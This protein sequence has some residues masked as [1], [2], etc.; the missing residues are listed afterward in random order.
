MTPE[1][2]LCNAG[3]FTSCYVPEE[4]HCFGNIKRSMMDV[5][6]MSGT[7]GSRKFII[8]VIRR[9]YSFL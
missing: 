4:V 3:N 9:N 1:S 8:Q 5:C 2:C 6:T 7:I